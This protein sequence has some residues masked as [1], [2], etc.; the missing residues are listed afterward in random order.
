MMLAAADRQSFVR[1]WIA[2]ALIYSAT[3]Y[4]VGAVAL[5]RRIA[6]WLNA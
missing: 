1:T 5:A 2:R 4:G 3:K 6:P